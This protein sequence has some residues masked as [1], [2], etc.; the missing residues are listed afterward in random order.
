MSE[1]DE[2][3]VKGGQ[4]SGLIDY[5]KFSA[6]ELQRVIAEAQTNLESLRERKK[7]ELRAKWEA[8]AAENG[9]TIDHV[10]AVAAE[11]ATKPEPAGKARRKTSLRPV[12]MKY[13]GPNGE[14]WSGRG[15]HPKWAQT[16]KAERGTLDDF[17]INKDQAADKRSK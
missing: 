8:E 11:P 9:L 7:I 4:D 13:R 5:S 15:R 1:T 14:L 10:V 2:A 17:L 12:E 16:I 3:Q 6:V